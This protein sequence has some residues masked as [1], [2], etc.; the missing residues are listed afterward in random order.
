MVF[1]VK[2]AGKLKAELKFPSLL[3]SSF[4]TSS[5]SLRVCSCLL[6]ICLFTQIC[7]LKFFTVQSS[8]NKEQE[9]LI[10]GFLFLF[11]AQKHVKVWWVGSDLVL[12]SSYT[13]LFS[14]CYFSTVVTEPIFPALSI[15]C[16]QLD[17]RS[18][19]HQDAGHNKTKNLLLK[20]KLRHQ[21]N[22]SK[23]IRSAQS[24]FESWTHHISI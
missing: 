21:L 8:L 14:K 6:S 22:S 1:Q 13:Q 16:T 23:K 24:D 10:D 17:R 4:C 3:Q 7:A 2:V 15:N 18:A 19:L 12:L 20:I 11:L 5:F 9:M